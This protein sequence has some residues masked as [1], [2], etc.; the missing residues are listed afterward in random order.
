MGTFQPSK[1]VFDSPAKTSQ[2]I[3]YALQNQVLVN[4]DNLEELDRIDKILQKLSSVESP[5]VGLRINPQTGAGTIQSTSTATITS[6]FGYAIEHRD[7]IVRAYL[8]Y[9]WLTGVHVH[10]GSQGCDFSL[11]A[12]SIRVVFD[13][14]MTINIERATKGFPP[15]SIF[16]IGGGHP[17]DYIN[18]DGNPTSFVEYAQILRDAI[19][20]LWT[21]QFQVITEF[22]R[23]ISAASAI[24]VSRVEY[25]K[26]AGNSLIATIHCG[27]DFI[28]R[29][30]YLPDK[31]KH[32]I[33]VYTSTGQRK[34]SSQKL[35]DTKITNT[36]IAGPLCFSGDLIS[37]S[38][39]LPEIVTGD[40]VVIHD[41]G[42]Y[43]LSMWSRYNSRPS[44]S[45][46]AYTLRDQQIE[47]SIL[48]PRETV[49]QVLA[50]WG[51]TTTND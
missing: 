25:T 34:K 32:R 30:A 33:T 41:V 19:P 40:Y 21:G 18:G 43:T 16:D 11:L 39:D 3:Q 2:E 51:N 29:S 5:R 22:G 9:P 13:L 7:E 45:V 24:A 42:A 28:L 47:F 46:Y 6:K 50:F 17:V 36:V 48:K 12:A 4:A 49:E 14:I 20:E 27:A 37:T 15:V 8:R 35:T 31:W 23:A 44:P 38:S 10:V 1:I 26:T